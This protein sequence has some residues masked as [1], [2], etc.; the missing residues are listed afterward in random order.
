MSIGLNRIRSHPNLRLDWFVQPTIQSTLDRM[1]IGYRIQINSFESMNI[2]K[3]VYINH[4]KTL[5]LFGLDKSY[6]SYLK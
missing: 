6:K 5:Q 4:Q 1:K 2:P 3:E